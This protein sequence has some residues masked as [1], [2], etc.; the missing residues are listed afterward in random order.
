MISTVKGLVI[1]YLVYPFGELITRRAV[2]PK[3]GALRRT[4]RRPFGERQRSNLERLANIIDAAREGSPYYK[5][6]LGSCGVDGDKIRRDVKFLQDIPYLTKDILREQGERILTKPPSNVPH[7]ISPTGGSTGARVPILYDLAAQDWSAAI[8]RLSREAI[9][10]RLRM[11]EVHFASDI[12][13]NT[14]KEALRSEFKKNFA[15]NRTNIFYSQLDD[16]ALEQIVQQIKNAMP[17]LVH[18]HPSTMNALANYV[19]RTSGNFSGLFE[20]FE[21]SGELLEEHV[22]RR[23]EHVCGCHVINRYGLAEFGI[24]AYQ[25]DPKNPEMRVYDTE[26]WPESVPYDADGTVLDEL[27]FTGLR[28]YFMPLIRYQTGDLGLLSVQESGITLTNMVGRMHD[29]IEL[30][31]KLCPTHYVMD[32]LQHRIGGIQDYQ[33]DL[34]NSD[35]PMIRVVL[36]PHGNLDHIRTSIRELW[37]DRIKVQAVDATDLVLVGWRSKFRHVLK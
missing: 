26:V 36:A 29:I 17:M 4:Y 2:S 28:N 23:I 8:T 18:G 30:G 31:G 24:V 1:E 7:V 12:G 10:A 21:S 3:L 5:E 33:I 19:V 13:H 34:R 35:D 11:P 15:F 9:G 27:V 14:T 22:R 32:I 37:G 6:L 20:F 16:L 25:Q